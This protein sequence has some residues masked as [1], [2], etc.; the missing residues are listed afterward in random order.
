MTPGRRRR[1]GEAMPVRGWFR[2]MAFVLYGVGIAVDLALR[3][4]LTDLHAS[5]RTVGPAGLAVA[6]QAS[7]FWP[8]DLLFR[9]LL[10]RLE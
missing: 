5:D 1:E 2:R 10:A 7:L 8:V 6:F 3:L 9:V 4:L